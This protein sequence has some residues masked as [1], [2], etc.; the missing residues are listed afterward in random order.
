[1][2]EAVTQYIKRKYNL[3]VGEPTAAQE[4]SVGPP[5]TVAAGEAWRY[6]P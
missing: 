1:M 6:S 3:L 2:D 5:M 4:R